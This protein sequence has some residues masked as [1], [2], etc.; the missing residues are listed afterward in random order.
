M[1][2]TARAIGILFLILLCSAGCSSVPDSR[3]VNIE[4]SEV[5]GDDAGL[6]SIIPNKYTISKKD[7]QLRVKVRL[8][9]NE[10]T[11]RKV[12]I[13][14]V[15]VVKDADGVEIVDGWWQME[16]SDS[17][18]NKFAAFLK[19]EE[20]QEMDF[21]FVNGFNSDYFK[22]ILT[23]AEGFCIDRLRLEE[24]SERKTSDDSG[25]ILEETIN[26]TKELIKAT[27]DLLDLSISASD[28]LNDL[29]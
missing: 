13:Y 10:G 8:K 16:L 6:I 17:E 28:F 4:Y 1:G 12:S 9:L 23:E 18:E 29:L 26:D 5:Y 2:K 22:Y 25:K 3:E 14:P 19:G 21:V 20:G 15:L 7:N 24:E 27:E 11:E